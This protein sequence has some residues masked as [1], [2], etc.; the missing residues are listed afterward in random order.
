MM[1]CC[2]STISMLARFIYVK[3]TSLIRVLTRKRLM[4]SLACLRNKFFLYLFS[5]LL[6]IYVLQSFQTDEHDYLIEK[7]HSRNVKTI[8]LLTNLFTGDKWD[9]KEL[10]EWPFRNCPVKSCYAFK[11]FKYKQKP[12]EKSD[13]VLVYTPQV[14]KP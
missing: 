14:N 13:A 11:P 5:I 10:G 4:C 8:Q 7:L 3:W 12:L 2:R 6:L 9:S 1:I